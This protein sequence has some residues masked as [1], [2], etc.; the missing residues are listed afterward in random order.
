MIKTSIFNT[1]SRIKSYSS[2]IFSRIT[3]LEDIYDQTLTFFEEY[4]N[5]VASLLLAM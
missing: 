2:Y 1:F 5:F 4:E 3:D